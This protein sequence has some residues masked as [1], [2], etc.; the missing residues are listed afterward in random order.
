MQ[1]SLVFGSPGI[2]R[3]LKGTLSRKSLISMGRN[4]LFK[5]GKLL[6]QNENISKITKQVSLLLL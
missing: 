2:C 5:P 1:S 4:D 3:C 6:N